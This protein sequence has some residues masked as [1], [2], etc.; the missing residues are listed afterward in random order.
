MASGAGLSGIGVWPDLLFPLLWV[1]PLL[2]IVS[3]QV[4]LEE[5][6]M[7]DALA[8]GDWR[9]FAASAFA[10]LLC[11]WFWEMWNYYSLARW[12]YAVPFVHKFL[13]FEMPVLGF[14][15]YLP[16]GLECAAI[17]SI[18]ERWLHRARAR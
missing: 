14:A 2:V 12:E 15:G 4:I 11:G 8:R 5:P 13:I 1:S 16:F 10:A 9:P 18:I 3:T 6:S 7:L 17:G